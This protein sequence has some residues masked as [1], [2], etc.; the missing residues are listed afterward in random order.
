MDLDQIRAEIL[1]RLG[2]TVLEEPPRSLSPF[3]PI[4]WTPWLNGWNT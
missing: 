1:A 4:T 2:I 3:R